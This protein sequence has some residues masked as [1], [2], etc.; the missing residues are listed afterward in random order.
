MEPLTPVLREALRE[1]EHGPLHRF[2]DWATADVP[3][4]C[5]GV[6]TVWR[7]DDVLYVGMGG[8][9]LA[10]DGDGVRGLR[11]RLASHASG[12]RS[13]NRF[14][15]YV[16]DRVVLPTLT[17]AQLE[18]VAAG[19]LAL[20]SL[21]RAYI[22]ERLGYRYTVVADQAAAFELERVVQRQGLSGRR[23]LFNAT[24]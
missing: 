10:K 5:V 2:A 21:V 23:P 8:K 18:D 11:S 3:N 16:C 14:C 22:H 24:R 12:Q 7:D 9:G 15:I 19:R 20:D 13:G 1:L 6:Y 4:R 17:P